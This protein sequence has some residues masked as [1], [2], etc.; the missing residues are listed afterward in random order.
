MADDVENHTLRLLQEMRTEMRESTAET[1]AE[2]RESIAGMRESLAETRAE[3]REGF[4]RMDQRLTETEQRLS[5]LEG[6]VSK[7]IDAVTNIA[8]VQETH[9]ALLTE[10]VESSRIAGGRL[11]TLE[12][13]LG[14]IEKQAGLAVA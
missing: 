14:R 13:R 3:M 10:L 4:A 9:S 8:K 7:V 11:N 6:T 12:A 2:M 5:G 1:R